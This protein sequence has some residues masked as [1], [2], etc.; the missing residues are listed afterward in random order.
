MK[1]LLTFFPCGL[2]TRCGSGPPEAAGFCPRSV[3]PSCWLFIAS[4]VVNMRNY[5]CLICLRCF[6]VLSNCLL[7]KWPAEL[8]GAVCLRSTT[9]D[10]W[11]VSAHCSR[12]HCIHSFG[13]L[14][15]LKFCSLCWFCLL[16]LS[17]LRALPKNPFVS[18]RFEVLVR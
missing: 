17:C 5:I 13:F 3:T 15:A 11:L 14:A 10:S 6:R 9:S 8:F 1:S 4:A 12:Q 2:Y 18:V 16:T 7:R